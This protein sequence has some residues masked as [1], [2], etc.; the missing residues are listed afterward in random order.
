MT[1]ALKHL[2]N[3]KTAAL[4]HRNPAACQPHTPYNIQEI[5]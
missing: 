5:T 4:T 3:F 2:S 1:P